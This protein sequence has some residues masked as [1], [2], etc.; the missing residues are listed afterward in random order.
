MGAVGRASLGDSDGIGAVLR[1][2]VAVGRIAG[3]AIAIIRVRISSFA[4]IGGFDRL[5]QAASGRPLR[6]QQR[7][8]ALAAKSAT[9]SRIRQ[10]LARGLAKF[11]RGRVFRKI[12]VKRFSQLFMI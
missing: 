11:G 2:I 7:R 9:G 5:V 12:K 6:Y 8:H 3:F 1:G 4:S 10:R